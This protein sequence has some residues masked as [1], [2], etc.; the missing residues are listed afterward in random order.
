MTENGVLPGH[1]KSSERADT[2]K[3]SWRDTT[4]PWIKAW[5]TSNAWKTGFPFKKQKGP[6]PGSPNPGQTPVT[7]IGAAWRY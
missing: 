2:C 4:D 6:H 3:T 5:N 7:A 1:A